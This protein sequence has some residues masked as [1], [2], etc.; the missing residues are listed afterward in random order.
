MGLKRIYRVF[1]KYGISKFA[2]GV[3]HD[4]ERN[5]KIMKPRAAAE[6]KCNEPD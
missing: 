1:N 6:V 2:T 3:M 4:D 5:F